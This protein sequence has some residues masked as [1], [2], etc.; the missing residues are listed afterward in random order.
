MK[1]K[2]ELVAKYGT[3]VA[4]EKLEMSKK[5]LLAWLR[6]N[7]DRRDRESWQKA[8]RRWKKENETI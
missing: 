4:A 7:L 6:D 1:E 8:C 3:D 2:V 5:E